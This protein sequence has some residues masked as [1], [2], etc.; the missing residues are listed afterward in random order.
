MSL[1]A[2]IFAPVVKRLATA[3]LLAQLLGACGSISFQRQTEDS[4]TFHATGWAVTLFSVDLPKSATNIARENI[5]DADLPNME[6]QSVKLRPY[7]GEFDWLL[8]L[9]CIRR[10]SVEG[11]WGFAGVD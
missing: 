6:V 7:L 5:S 9:I 4:G 10:A 11:T 1:P 3:L 2:A 8:D